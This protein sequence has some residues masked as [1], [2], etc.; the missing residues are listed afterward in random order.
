MYSN[1]FPLK[2]IL[3]KK[4]FEKISSQ[5]FLLLLHIKKSTLA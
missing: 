1:E 5:L 3:E 2:S 4:K